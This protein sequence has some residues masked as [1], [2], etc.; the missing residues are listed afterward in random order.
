MVSSGTSWAGTQLSMALYWLTWSLA[1]AASDSSWINYPPNGFATMTH[2][3]LPLGDIAACGCAPDSTYYPT[4]A[5]NQMAYGIVYLSSLIRA[6]SEM[7][8]PH[9]GSSVAFGPACGICFNLTL[10]NTFLSDPPFY[11]NVT[12]SVVIKVTD[13]CPLSKNGWCSA[14]KNKPNS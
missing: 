2:Y 4:A 11:P 9:A 3:G 8:E 1:V 14:T 5:L 13:L 10:L 12:K 7:T 6:H